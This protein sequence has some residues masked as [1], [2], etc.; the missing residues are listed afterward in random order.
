MVG[1]TGSGKS[2]LLKQLQGRYPIHGE[3]LSFNGQPWD[4]WNNKTIREKIGV[5]PQE[6]MIFSKTIKD[7]ILF[8]HHDHPKQRLEE[9]LYIADLEKDLAGFPEGLQTLCGERGYSLSGGQKQRISLARALYP[10]P[11][12]VILDDPMSAVDASTEK[13]MME[14][15]LKD[16]VGKTTILATH[17]LSQIM[18]FDQI[19]V[20]HQGQM[21]EKG[22]HDEL[23][24]NKG[25]YYRQFLRQSSKSKVEGGVI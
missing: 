12:V 4:H 25:W 6:A 19:I 23:M 7:N 10:D 21:L 13:N 24:E 14:R 2:T 8:S 11:E 3:T 17:R 22:T 18:H 15:I 1:P 9:V 5:S 20:L 16:R